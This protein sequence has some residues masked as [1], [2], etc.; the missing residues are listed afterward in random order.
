VRHHHGWRRLE[1]PHEHAALLVRREI[2]GPDHSVKPSFPEPRLRG[3]KQRSSD[4][5]VVHGVEE[6][7]EAGAV[8]VKVVVPA[9]QDRGD[10]TDDVAVPPGDEIRHFRVAVKRMTASIE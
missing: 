1:S 9:I 5:V 6:S 2:D 8:A 3:L 10:A 4:I 7:E